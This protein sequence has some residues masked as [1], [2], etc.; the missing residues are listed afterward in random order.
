M[1]VA[2]LDDG[3][4]QVLAIPDQ[5]SRYDQFGADTLARLQAGQRPIATLHDCYRAMVVIDTIYDRAVRIPFE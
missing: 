3:Q 1:H 4:R 5:G 2:T